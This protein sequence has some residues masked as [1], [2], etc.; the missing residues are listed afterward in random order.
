MNLAELLHLCSM[1]SKSGLLRV[2]SGANHG[3][4]FLQNGRLTYALFGKSLG[5]EAIFD[6]LTSHDSNAELEEGIPSPGGNVTISCEEALLEAARR[7]DEKKRRAASK[8]SLLSPANH[9]TALLRL[10]PESTGWMYPLSR[11]RISLGR[12]NKNDICLEHET[13]SGHHCRLQIQKTDIILNDLESLNGT[14]VN[15]KKITMIALK[16]NDL[17]QIGDATFRIEIA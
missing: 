4:I 9:P 3:Q 12:S 11:E 13:V 14:Y 5:N 16:H 2:R 1:S 15:G 8:T 17:I 6:M 7:S 10:L